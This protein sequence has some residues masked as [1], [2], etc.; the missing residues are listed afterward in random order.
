MYLLKINNYL[1][2]LI[3]RNYKTYKF[4]LNLKNFP[5]IVVKKLFL[6]FGYDISFQLMKSKVK[7]NNKLLNLNIGAG[8]YVIPEFKSLDFYSPHYYKN[9]DEF[10]RDRIEY[11]IRKDK[12]PFL[13][14]SIDNIYISHVIEHI[15]NEFVIKFLS[16]SYRVLKKDCILRIACP[17]AKYLFKISKFQNTYWEWRKD[18]FESRGFDWRKVTKEDCLIREIST[19]KLRNYESNDNSNFSYNSLLNIENYDSLKNLIKN[20]LT[21]RF[22]FPGDHIN[23]WDYDELA[24]LGK[25]V[26]FANIIKSKYRGSVSS[27]MQSPF[28]DQTCPGMSLYVDMVK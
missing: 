11:D 16:E 9:K 26:G 7:K 5:N 6:F 24:F 3:K 20:D 10:L 17:D 18:W 25:K 4:F 12:I 8:S 1:K 28:F 14:S 2:K 22:N 15:E 19:P 27:L 13:D 21:F 23:Y